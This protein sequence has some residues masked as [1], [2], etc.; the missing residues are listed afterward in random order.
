M[1]TFKRWT[2][3]SW[4]DPTNVR[5][6]S[7]SSWVNVGFVRR[8]SG[9]AW[10]DVYPTYVDISVSVSP[11]SYQSATIGSRNFTA[12][13]SGGD[14]SHTYSWSIS[15]PTNFSLANASSQTC[16]VS[17]SSS[18]AGSCTVTC[19]VNDGTSSDSANASITIGQIQ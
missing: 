18:N 14:G 13:V 9:S 12:S 7:G 3:S 4:V 1:S 8:W 11:T 6:W 19:V 5:R 16:N 17:W 10:V 15:N 2:G